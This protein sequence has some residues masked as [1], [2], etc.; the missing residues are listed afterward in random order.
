MLGMDPDSPSIGKLLVFA[1]A[2]KAEGVIVI[3][4]GKLR[5]AGSAVRIMTIEAEDPRI[6]MATPLEV[7]PL[8]VMG[9]RMSLRVSP[10]SRLELEIVGKGLSQFIRFVVLIIPWILKGAIRNANPS[11][12][13]LAAHLQTS[14]VR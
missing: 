13:A 3:G 6:E 7:H 2:G 14:L 12:V 8:L 9:F 11:R 5:S 10:D 1:M 4:L